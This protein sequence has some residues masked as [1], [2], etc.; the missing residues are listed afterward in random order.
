M[1]KAELRIEMS[2]NSVQSTI[3]EQLEPLSKLMAAKAGGSLPRVFYCVFD[4][5]YKLTLGE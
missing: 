4:V 1:Q 5:G 3:S 2:I